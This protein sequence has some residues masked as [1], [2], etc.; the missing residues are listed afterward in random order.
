MIFN[1]FSLSIIRIFSWNNNFLEFWNLQNSSKKNDV[2]LF[3]YFVKK[4]RNLWKI[5]L[6]KHAEDCKANSMSFIIKCIDLIW[7][8]CS[9]N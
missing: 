6:S 8:V 3:Y 1:I 5:N 2:S 9:F 7:R 4:N